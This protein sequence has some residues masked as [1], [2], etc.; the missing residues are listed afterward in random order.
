[1]TESI[2]TSIDTS[3]DAIGL[4]DDDYLE[5]NANRFEKQY[6]K[7][8]S[9]NNIIND[10]I[11]DKQIS[12]TSSNI[13]DLNKIDFESN[14]DNH[15][16]TF[17]T[18][19]YL[20]TLKFQQ[21]YN[22]LYFCNMIIFVDN[23][24]IKIKNNCFNKNI[25]TEDDFPGCIFFPYEFVPSLKQ[26]IY[27]L[28]NQMSNAEVQK[29]KVKSGDVF[30]YSLFFDEGDIKKNVLYKK[31][32][33]MNKI[34]FTP[35]E[36]FQIKQTEYKIRGFCQIA[37]ELGAKKID[38]K[39]EKNSNIIKNM[40]INTSINSEIS[41]IA[42]NLGLGINNSSDN[43]EDYTYTLTYPAI[44]TI[45][46]NENTIKSK[47]RKNKF[48]ISETMYNSSL[49][50]QYLISS[51]CRHFISKY[52]TTFTLDTNL[53]V[54]KS[55]ISNLKTHGI[56]VN[57]DINLSVKEHNYL[58]IIT[59]IEFSNME[60][61]NDNLNAY[62]VSL[63]KVGFSFLINSIK[64]R[65]DFIINGV[66]KIMNFLELYIEK[67]LKYVN[68]KKYYTVSYIITQIKMNLSLDEYS[69]LLCNYFNNNSQWIHFTRFIDLLACK[70]VSNDKLGYLV[71]VYNQDLTPKEKIKELLKYIQVKCNESNIEEQFWKMIQPH[72]DSI[73][74]Y[75]EHKLDKE[76]D[77]LNSFNW[78]SLLNLVNTIGKYN[79]NIENNNSEEHFLSLLK[80]MNNGYKTYE[81]EKY[82][83][84]F[85][86]KHCYLRYNTDKDLYLLSPLIEKSI[87]FESFIQNN[88]NSLCLLDKYINIKIGK[89]K[90]MDEIINIIYKQSQNEDSIINTIIDF[91]N[92]NNNY[93][94]FNKKY[95]I[96]MNNENENIILLS[97][98]NSNTRN[99]I[100]FTN[101]DI[102]I[103]KKFMEKLLL[104]NEKLDINKIPLN[105]YGFNKIMNNFN[106]G[107]KEYV[108]ENVIKKFISLYCQYNNMFYNIENL[109][110][111]NIM[112]SNNINDL[113]ELLQINIIEQPIDVYNQPSTRRHMVV[114][115]NIFETH[116]LLNQPSIEVYPEEDIE[117]YSNDKIVYV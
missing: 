64:N 65:D 66:F 6:Y 9:C 91:F 29:Q 57:M 40:K 102:N 80:N 63:N 52:S 115:N 48:I 51:R 70:T 56:N 2:D 116:D 19:D 75:L 13:M 3:I 96:I 17:N 45:N 61:N 82:I 12:T 33:V 98:L 92:N 78:Y 28:N 94:Y 95:S 79:I 39:F 112:K 83:L 113:N 76:Y 85:I 111:D 54:D 23:K 11:N 31:L 77:I 35:I 87:Y 1:M 15:I 89:I 37:E 67:I 53:N 4:E 26:D 34:I 42:G 8:V 69:N 5:I 27:L 81:F 43:N 84:P 105:G 86:T 22:I 101:N 114:N 108:F 72:N 24:K 73:Y 62:S 93:P 117:V 58:K 44:N 106:N 103:I 20:L 60:D 107:N 99:T 36:Q 49:E 90:Q 30:I 109:T 97:M 41:A 47:I 16:P 71:I 74:Y 25:L 7:N 21:V 10:I 55:L 110:I 88:I 38:I 59:D 100:D 18:M 104:Y 32:E 46:L 50:L 14:N 68:K